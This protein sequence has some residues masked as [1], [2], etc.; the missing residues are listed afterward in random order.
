[1]AKRYTNCQGQPKSGEEIMSTLEDNPIGECLDILRREMNQHSN[2][3]P[4]KLCLN[5]KFYEALAQATKEERSSIFNGREFMDIPIVVNDEVADIWL[6][7]Y[8]EV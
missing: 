3:R 1:M 7:T 4:R 5:W 6:F 2:L 8:V